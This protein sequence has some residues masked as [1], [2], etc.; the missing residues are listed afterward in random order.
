MTVHIHGSC[1]LALLL[2]LSLMRA[3]SGNT[4]LLVTFGK[5]LA[6]TALGVKGALRADQV[7]VRRGGGQGRQCSCAVQAEEL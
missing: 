7:P 2:Q 6:A 5:H 1:Y 3:K 4:L